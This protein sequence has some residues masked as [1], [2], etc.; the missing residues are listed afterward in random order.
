MG[1]FM[2][3][4]MS[5]KEELDAVVVDSKT[6]EEK[7]KEDCA[8]LLSRILRYL[9][10][11][12][13]DSI[14][15][16][17]GIHKENEHAKNKIFVTVPEWHSAHND[18]SEMLRKCYADAM[19]IV[20]NKG[21]HSVAFPILGLER[22][23]CPVDLA[24]DTA[25]EILRTYSL[26][27][28]VDIYLIIHDESA[29]T[30]LRQRISSMVEFKEYVSAHYEEPV[31]YSYSGGRSDSLS[32]KAQKAATEIQAILPE[33]KKGELF[34]EYLQ[35]LIQREGK[36]N[37]QV[38][39]AANLDRKLFSKIQKEPDSIPSKRTILALAIALQLSIDETNALLEQAGFALSP[40]VRSDIII[41][42]FIQNGQY[43]IQIINE[44]LYV[45]GE[46]L[47]GS[48]SWEER[49]F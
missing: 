40:S 47:L 46:S 17:K 22:Q 8:G 12:V 27:Y 45:C 31:K 9:K 36:T 41:E 35:T 13:S 26:E 39:K 28:D 10:K 38:Y 42:Y 37:A 11:A 29:R 18:E 25:L 4:S 16:S 49:M 5:G 33:K 2:E 43:D 44:V 34:W 30:L 7:T 21:G 1:F 19:E 23:D 24:V 48:M 14:V 6:I 3:Y 15:P 20:M 32:E